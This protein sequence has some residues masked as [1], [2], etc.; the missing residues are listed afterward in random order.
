MVG[1]R[2]TEHT[3]SGIEIECLRCAATRVV[4]N[5]T[6]VELGECGVCGDVG[7]TVANALS[8]SERLELHAARAQPVR[9]FG[10]PAAGR[11]LLVTF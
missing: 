8:G 11:A 4:T 3:L 7:W 10:F 1:P 9:A 2:S 5:L 6:H